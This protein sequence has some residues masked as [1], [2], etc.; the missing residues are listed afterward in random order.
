MKY[1]GG[2]HPEIEKLFQGQAREICVRVDR[3]FSFLL[4]IQWLLAIGIS[5]IA[6]ASS[7]Q[8]SQINPS[9]ITFYGSLLA[10]PA[11][12]LAWSRA[13]ERTTRYFIAL[14]QV[15]FCL[16][17]P[18]AWGA[19]ELMCF[20]IFVALA[21]VAFYQDR[22]LLIGA[23]LLTILLLCWRGAFPYASDEW[24]WLK[25]AA[26]IVVENIILLL[27]MSELRKEL[28][29]AASSKYEL[30]RA[31][32]EALRLSSIKSNFLSRMSHEIR[33]PLSSIIGFSD[34]L[35]D[36]DLNEEQEEYVG[37]IHRCSE[38]L[39]H[40]INDILDISK[41]ENGLLQID[42]HR[43][44]LKELHEDI[45]K[46]FWIKCLEKGLELEL[47]VDESSPVH[48]HGD[49]HRLRQILMNLVSN[50]V[51][52]TE[53]GK[54]SIEV[55]YEPESSTYHWTIRDTGKG[56]HQDNLGKLFTSFYQE[57]PSV[58]RK[59]GGSGLGLMISKNLVELMGGQ[60]SVQ[61]QLGEGTAFSF[62]LKL[63][64]NG[65]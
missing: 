23:S 57:D 36:T 55:R 59:Y 35:T 22:A 12:C 6:T 11:F 15:L 7:G 5:V 39:L 46:M 34:I 52:F 27:G 63:P 17:L 50:A 49:S 20:H 42:A 29:E 19:P 37:T 43:F 65:L 33:T 51:K 56:I 25:Y 28:M 21:A 24:A 31:R 14:A 58:S 45:Y 30:M 41:I 26:W 8:S 2:N 38:T 13:G 44:D 48:V 60:I 4:V 16:L 32:E 62:S 3:A 53:R 61:S 54:V 10:V 9:L 40:L 1:S 18:Y 47:K 64:E